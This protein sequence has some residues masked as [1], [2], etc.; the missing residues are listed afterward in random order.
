MIFEKNEFSSFS[1]VAKHC[2]AGTMSVKRF[3]IRRVVAPVQDQGRE[4]APAE[5]QVHCLLKSV[6]CV[7]SIW[8]ELARF[9]LRN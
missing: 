5:R 4:L 8:R 3:V 6:T 9:Y 2:H 1:P 7:I